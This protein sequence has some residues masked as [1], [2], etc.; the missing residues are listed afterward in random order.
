MYDKLPNYINVLGQ[1]YRIIVNKE[2]LSNTSYYGE[3]DYSKRQII[4]NDELDTEEQWRTLAHEVMHSVIYRCGIRFS[5]GLSSEL[6]E[7]IAESVGNVI[8]DILF[9]KGLTYNKPRKSKKKE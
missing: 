8:A 3:C 1:K 6:E 4:I 9:H 7:I 2:K 5:G